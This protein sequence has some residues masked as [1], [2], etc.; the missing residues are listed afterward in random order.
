MKYLVIF[1]SFFMFGCQT[2]G[3]T[4]TI[5]ERSQ[6]IQFIHELESLSQDDI[7]LKSRLWIGENFNSANDVITLDE[8]S[9]GVLR[10]TAISSGPY[11]FYERSFIFNFLIE[12]RDGRARLT[13]S[14]LRPYDTYMGSIKVAGLTS[15]NAAMHQ[16]MVDKLHELSVSFVD[17]MYVIEEDW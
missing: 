15:R 2:T 12:S 8:L 3:T 6:P 7:H 10:G 1:F 14:N 16:V 9:S 11:A 5:E 17:Y 4:Q 13:F